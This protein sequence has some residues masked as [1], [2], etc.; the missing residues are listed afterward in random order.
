MGSPWQGPDV[1]RFGR[2]ELDP[3]QGLRRGALEVRLT[4]KSLAVLQVLAGRAGQVVPK[5]ALF[6]AVWPGTA[7]S[8]AA[9]TSCIQELRQA[10]GDDARRPKFIETL[11]RRGYRF[12]AQT[13]AAPPGRPPAAAARAAAWNAVTLV[14]REPVLALL[15]SARAAADAGTRQVVFVI[16]EAGVGKTAVVEAFASRQAGMTTASGRCLE[17]S[18]AAEPYA[19]LLEALTRLCREP[20]GDGVLEALRRCAP[21]WLAQLPALVPPPEAARLQRAAAGATRE[22]M[23]RELVDAVET[24]AARTPLLIWLD[25]LHWTDTATLDWIGAF[26][27]R[28]DPARVLLIATSR[29]F[30][31]RETVKTPAVSNRLRLKGFCREI[32]LEGLDEAAVAEFV[33]QR[34]PPP[35]AERAR[36]I[37]LAGAIHRH[38]GG[39]PLFVANVVDDLASRGLLL[40]EADGWR[41]AAGTAA[42]DLGVPATV[43]RM[44]ASQFER[45]DPDDQ[46]LLEAASMAIQSASAALVAAAVDM[47]PARVETR[48]AALARQ[49]QFVRETEVVEWPDGTVAAAFEFIHDLHRAAIAGRVPPGRRAAMNRLLGARLETA[50]GTRAHEIAGTLAW[51]FQFGHDHLRTAVYRQH[52]ADTARRRGAYAEAQEH[53]TLGLAALWQ[54]PPGAE[55]TEHEATLRI[56]LGAVVMAQRGWGAEEARLNYERALALC[57]ELGDTPRLFPA[58][59]GLW[60]YYWGRGPMSAAHELAGD[61]VALANRSGDSPLRLQ[62]HHASWATAFSQGDL[63]T[64]L[65]HAEAG[66]RLYD[67]ERDAAAAANYGSHDAGVCCRWFAARA[68]VLGGRIADAVRTSGEAIAMA[69]SL[70]HPV[71]LALALVF[72]AAVHQ[73][74][75]DGAAAAE[76]AAAAAVIA[77]EQDLRLILAWASTLEGWAAVECGRA[78]EGAARIEQGIADARET[79]SEQFL[80]HFLGL[81]AETHLRAGRSRAGLEAVGEA[82]TIAARTGERFHEAELHRLRGELMLAS[83]REPAGRDAARRDAEDAFQ[84]AADVATAQGA[85]LLRLRAAVSLGRVWRASGKAEDAR[86]LVGAAVAALPGPAPELDAIDAAELTEM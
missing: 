82:L 49:R 9:L 43:S 71:T 78:V 76:H 65:A 21:T 2:Y 81:L 23:L 10:L 52:A 46:T 50:Y 19:P 72:A 70:D 48:L 17:L 38:T 60:L 24:I 64:A 62:A 53:F 22:R 54:Q 67:R 45:L 34:C 75:R 56:G 13:A 58:L 31:E 26:A 29:R 57:R 83:A 14:G 40:K 3:T 68:M 37:R 55:R 47:P 39:N 27:Q 32:E 84:A 59:W 18:G 69:R 4:P 5:A 8:D 80:P 41:V 11:H 63:E 66:Q 30:D 51:H 77:R 74:R 28:R 36:L 85:V 73:A 44:L 61:L 12:V 20:G 35:P 25:D 6:E 86:R 16:G 33:L 15:D 1:I 7:V 42:A 79:G